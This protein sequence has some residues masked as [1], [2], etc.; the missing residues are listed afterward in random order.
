MVG[1]NFERLIE[2][3]LLAQ[4]FG[5]HLCPSEQPLEDAR[6]RLQQLHPQTAVVLLD[7]DEN[8][9]DLRELLEVSPETACVLLSPRFPPS[10]ALARVVD[11]CGGAILRQEELPLLVVATLT[12]M[13][14]SRRQRSRLADA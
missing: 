10:T 2:L 5:V 13:L 8:V 3:S 14:E 11:A 12:A 4:D 1:R 9:V 7:G 6:H